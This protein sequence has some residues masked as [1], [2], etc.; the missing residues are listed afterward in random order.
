MEGRVSSPERVLM[1][2]AAWSALHRH[3]DHA[4]GICSAPG[5]LRFV[6]AAE[7]KAQAAYERRL[8]REAKKAAAE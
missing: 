6:S 4:Y 7:R 8:A 2:K 1:D 3:C 5:D